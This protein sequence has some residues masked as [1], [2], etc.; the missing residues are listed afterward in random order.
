MGRWTRRELRPE[1]AQEDSDLAATHTHEVQ[2][3]IE[4]SENILFGV[5]QRCPVRVWGDDQTEVLAHPN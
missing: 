3:R 1:V 5:R 2:G 4:L